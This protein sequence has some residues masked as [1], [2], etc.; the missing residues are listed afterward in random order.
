MEILAENVSY[1]VAIVLTVFFGL[2]AT[3]ALVVANDKCED[4]FERGLATVVG[5]FSILMVMSI[6]YT[7]GGVVTF[8]AIVRTGT[9]YTSKAT[10]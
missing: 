4:T 8:N 5:V 1:V 9:K 2:L 10:K 3:V 6:W 7:G